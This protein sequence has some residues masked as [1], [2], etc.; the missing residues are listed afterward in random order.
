MRIN[1]RRFAGSIIL[2]WFASL[3]LTPPRLYAHRLFRR[4]SGGLQS[5]L[6]ITIHD[7]LFTIHQLSTYY[8][9]AHFLA[10]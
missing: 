10:R 6:D 2:A 1:C 7:L 4:L 3:G 9:V 8:L 5:V